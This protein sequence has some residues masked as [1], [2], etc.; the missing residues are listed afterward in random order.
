M[1]KFSD[2]TLTKLDKRFGLQQVFDLEILNRWLSADAEVSPADQA[3]L[4]NLKNKATI[5]VESWNEQEYWAYV[6][7][8]LLNYIDFTGINLIGATFVGVEQTNKNYTCF[9]KRF[10]IGKVDGEEISGYPDGLIASGWREPEVPYFCLQE[11]KQESEP[12]SDPR[13]QC[14][15]AML[16]AQTLN[17]TEQPI[18]GCYTRGRNWFFMV[19]AGKYYAISNAYT[20]THDD[21]FEIYK[22]LRTLKQ[23]I[24]QFVSI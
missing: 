19:L 22:I 17:Q 4:L 16:V 8:P 15:A 14:L 1:S 23:I 7:V 3:F 12:N 11:W 24:H 9:V 2:W 21:I 5:F 6:I 20:I 13:G 10:F 18:Y